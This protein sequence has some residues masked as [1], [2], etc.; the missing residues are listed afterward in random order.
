M[1]EDARGPDGHGG[2]EPRS[3]L[4]RGTSHGAESCPGETRRWGGTA[5]SQPRQ[6]PGLE[7]GNLLTYVTQLV[8]GAHP[9]EGQ[10][11]GQP[12][13]AGRRAALPGCTVKMISWSLSSTRSAGRSPRYGCT[14]S[15]EEAAGASRSAGGSWALGQPGDGSQ[16]GRDRASLRL[17]DRSSAVPDSYRSERWTQAAATRRPLQFPGLRLSATADASPR[18]FPFLVPGCSRGSQGGHT[19]TGILIFGQDPVTQQLAGRGPWLC[20]RHRGDPRAQARPVLPALMFTGLQH[21]LAK[22]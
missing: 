1:G 15:W 4:A 22:S 5:A 8:P 21:P 17:G 12:G 13:G 11:P 10:L 18:P 6:T 7:G 3:R 20:V 19:S 14:F 9:E 2:A 16:H